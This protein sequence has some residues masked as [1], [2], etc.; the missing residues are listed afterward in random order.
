M[1]TPHDLSTDERKALERLVEANVD[2][3]AG[4]TEAASIAHDEEL[5]SLFDDIAHTRRRNAAELGRQLVGA[6]ASPH[7]TGSVKAATHRAWMDLRGFLQHGDRA[8]VLAEVSRG[9]HAMRERYERVLAS[10]GGGTLRATVD[11]QYREVVA[12]L[13][14]VDGLLSA[15]GS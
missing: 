3:I 4:Y 13:E 15:T 14:R 5:T 9:E 12:Q 2:S 11:G 1:T 8:A 7:F 10:L 6:G